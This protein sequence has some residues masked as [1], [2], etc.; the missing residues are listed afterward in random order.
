MNERRDG[1]HDLL[2][3]AWLLHSNLHQLVGRYAEQEVCTVVATGLEEVSVVAQFVAGEPVSDGDGLRYREHLGEGEGGGG[4][5]HQI[6]LIFELA[7]FFKW[8]TKVLT[9]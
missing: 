6:S 9:K 4:T 5:R 1:R 3:V 8:N 7:P 2:L